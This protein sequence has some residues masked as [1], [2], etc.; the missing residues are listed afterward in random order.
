MIM[1]TFSLSSVYA[2]LTSFANLENFWSLFDTAFGSSCDSAKAANFKYQWQNYN[3]SQ[4]PQI[5]IVSSDVLGSA[6][7]AYGIS[8]NR[9]YLSDQFV[10]SANQQSLEAVILEEFGHFVDAQVNATDTAGDEGELFSDLVRGVSLSPSELGRIKTENDHAVV[11]INGQETAIEQSL[12]QPTIAWTKLFGTSLAQANALTTGN[13]GAIY[14]SGFTQDGQIYS[15]GFYDAFITKYNPD[16]TKVWTELLGTSR[17]DQ[18][19]A[20]TTGNDGAIYVSGYTYGNLDGQTNSDNTNG[21]TDAFITK[22]N[23]NGTK[24]WTK[25]LGTLNYD[26]AN[27]LTT[28]NDGAIYVSGYTYGNL[29]GQT[30][31]GLQDAFITKYNPDGTKVWTRLLGTG[32]YDRASALTTGNDGSIYVSGLT[33]GSLDGQIH[34][35][36]SYEAFITK[37]TP[38]GTKVWTKLL[39][40][41]GNDYASA[42]TTGNDG[43]I[44]VSGDT[45]GNLDGQTNS[46]GN[47]DAFITKYNPD[48]T[49]VWTR[50]LG[51]GYE[52]KAN[53][54]TTGNDG[55]IYVSGFTGGNLDGQINSGGSY[56]AFIAKYNPDG[57][58]V[59]T[60]LLGTSSYD[61]A[62]ALTTGNDGAIYV[63]GFT[64]GN[65]DG[66]TNY[67]SGSAFITKYQDAPA[68]T[69]TLA[70]APASV[71]ED[72]TPNLIYT[73]TRTGD[74]TNALTV[75]YGIT[76][77]ADATDYTGATP[78]TGKTITFAVGSSTATLT[79]DPTA[80]AVIEPDETV[81]LTLASGTDYIIETTNS[82]TGNILNDD[83]T[84]QS[85]TDLAL[86]NST[87]AEN[88][89][90]GT[91]V[92]TFSSTDPDTGNLFTYS[93]VT[94]TGDTDNTLFTLT[95]NQLQSN[96][97]FDY[98]AQNS[99][100]IRVQT[101]DQ[102][103]L[104]F[105]KE[106]IIGI[107]NVNEGTLSFSSPQFSINEDGTTINEIT[108][109]RTE[110]STGE[111]SITLNLTDGT[112]TAGSDYDGT[113]ITIT[114][115]DGETS[116]TVDIPIVD[117]TI[118]E[119]DETLNLTLSD[120]TGGATLGT[121]QTSTLTILDND[122]PNLP[123]L[124]QVR[125]NLLK[126]NGGN[127]GDIINNDQIGL[128]QSFFV[129]ILVGDFRDNAV[130]V[131]GLQ[132]DF[133]W[134]G[135][136][137][138]SINSPF[139][140]ANIITSQF[141][142]LQGGT[143]DNPNGLI[144]DLSGGSLPAFE[145]GQ[146]IGINQLD[147][148]A[149]L[150]FY[151]ENIT[152]GTSYLNTAVDSV[153]LADD[154]SYVLDVETAQPIEVF[155]ST[156]SITDNS[157][158]A[159][160]ASIRFTTALSQ[161]RKNY[162][163][164]NFVRPNYADSSKYFDITNTG[165][166]KLTISDLRINVTGVSTDLDLTKGDLLLNP[167]E[168]QRV[169]LTYTPSAAKE[170]FE[171]SDA[172]ILVTNAINSP[173]LAIALSGKSTFNS[174]VNYD[175]KVGAGDLGSLNQGKANLNEG[176]YDPTAHIN[177]DG[178]F[179]NLDVAMLQSE[180]KLSLF[181]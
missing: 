98:E 140:P 126:D 97:I 37:Y 45:T 85:P 113:P 16:G 91:A 79:I 21:Y 10:S 88:Q 128:Y 161:F 164:S 152:D 43:A 55:A 58:K 33:F 179:N 49:K 158:D 7:G 57:T 17:E 29:D 106:L 82:I 40:T 133:N 160:D 73:F 22:Y 117:D 11:I 101:T 50:L 148:F 93:L 89:A 181:A 26:S 112:A 180:N 163:D 38:D 19:Y 64:G 74:T 39:G 94:G 41:S 175:G 145:L 176:I 139:D 23:P 25:L 116:K 67:A 141:P 142:L 30:S 80:D 8:T 95:D 103:G 121:Q 168:S 63:S 87:I 92:G 107:T 96:A 48:G 27:A 65:L 114:F 13:D 46:G 162:Q 110:G 59:W 36:G 44:Y 90:I 61:Q 171:R 124:L 134:D 18:A 83:T 99:Y 2:Q 66:Q 157:G 123:S 47:Y 166:G 136:I 167:N 172:L 5:E 120:P 62:Y 42:L 3:F 72:G 70:V 31:G 151:A 150:H 34:S 78:G 51:T 76:G 125:L 174:D 6:N 28:G 177:G 15:G 60:K 20:L 56:D 129:E 155:G 159:N 138:E 108:I 143:L 178:F 32:S 137:L 14:V 154:A 169:K 122:T 131:N 173:E 109:N 170:V 71:T 81:I 135:F 105:E 35:G 9:I 75:N 102:S 130:G 69:I 4:F 165:I 144:D 86:S 153:S 77:T 84:N 132:L 24:V 54:L 53:A 149:L 147:R 1:S 115:A 100:S 104:F 146:A 127:P 52:D 12:S 119:G 118:Y 111:V 68:V 156:I